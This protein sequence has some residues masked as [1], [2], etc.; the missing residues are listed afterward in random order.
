MEINYLKEN[1]IIMFNGIITKALLKTLKKVKDI[2]KEVYF[3][4][5]F[6]YQI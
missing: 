6:K 1:L 3:G 2:Q 4:D 5:F